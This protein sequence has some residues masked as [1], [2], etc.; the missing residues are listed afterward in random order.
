MLTM[1]VFDYLFIS[2]AAIALVRNCLAVPQQAPPPN[3]ASSVSAYVS[4]IIAASSIATQASKPSQ[5]VKEFIALG[6]SFTAG[7][8]S[9]GRDDYIKQSGDCRRYMEAMPL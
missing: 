5:Q 4:S 7:I 3:T 1:I 2:L 9:N 6:D 8:G